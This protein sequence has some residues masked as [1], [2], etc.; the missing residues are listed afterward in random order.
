MPQSVAFIWKRHT[1]PWVSPSVIALAALETISTAL[2]WMAI[3]R[4]AM[5]SGVPQ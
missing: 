2:F 1:Y 5:P 4:D 3:G